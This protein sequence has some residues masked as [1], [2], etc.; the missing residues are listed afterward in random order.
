MME[1]PTAQVK[2]EQIFSTQPKV[3]QNKFAYLNKMVP[4]ALIKLIAFFEQCQATNKSSG[5]LEKIA[6]DKKQPKEKKIAHLTAV[7]S[8]E[9]SY[10]Q[11]SC[12]KYRDY[13]WS[14]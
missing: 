11:H 6:K 13:R 12:H 10:Q 3:H 9:L 8:C 7:R 5:V 2:S 14:D 1:V 4:T